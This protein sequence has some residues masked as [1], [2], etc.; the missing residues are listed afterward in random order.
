M[1]TNRSVR[2]HLRQ[3]RV[4]LRPAARRRA[5]VAGLVAGPFAAAGFGFAFV[6]IPQLFTGGS[7]SSWAF[8][9]IGVVSI[10][11]ASFLGVRILRPHH[12]GTRSAM[13]AVVLVGLPLALLAQT[14]IANVILQLAI[15]AGPGL[16]PAP[17]LVFGVSWGAVAAPGLLLGPLATWWTAHLNRY[18]PTEL[19]RDQE[20]AAKY[21]AT[22]DTEPGTIPS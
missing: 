22:T 20:R 2:D 21:E 13:Q 5:L 3:A 11:I 4:R 6:G 7:G 9:V 18:L 14:I 12:R 17:A 16:D 19:A 10:V 8:A 15:A 1:T